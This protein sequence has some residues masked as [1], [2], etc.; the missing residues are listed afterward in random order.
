MTKKKPVFS[1]DLCIGCGICVTACP[2]S[3]LELTKTDIDK[4]HT[5]FPE[6]TDRECISCGQ[7]ATVCPMTA[8]RMEEPA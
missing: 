2:V 5:A 3:V 1:Y 8:V 6:M 4:I 7:C